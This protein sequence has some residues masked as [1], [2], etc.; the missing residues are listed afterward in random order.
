[1]A[2][3]FILDPVHDATTILR[4]PGLQGGLKAAGMHCRGEAPL[5]GWVIG[6][7]GLDPINLPPQKVE[8]EKTLD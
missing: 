5:E 8:Y 1:M 7:V 3:D 6:A 2:R 4:S